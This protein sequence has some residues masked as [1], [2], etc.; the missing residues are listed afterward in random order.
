MSSIDA[1]FIGGDV[2]VEG[3]VRGDCHCC[4]LHGFPLY[5]HYLIGQPKFS[6]SAREA[7]DAG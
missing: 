4:R 6:P 5:F 7:Q 2:T 3:S 1:A